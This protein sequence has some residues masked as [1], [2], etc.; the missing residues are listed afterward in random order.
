MNRN[1]RGYSLIFLLGLIAI[2]AALTAVL[3]PT[4]AGNKTPTADTSP[5]LSM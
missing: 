4:V 2:V 3:F 1:R 5:Q